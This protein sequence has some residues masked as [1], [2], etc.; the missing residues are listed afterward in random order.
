LLALLHQ[1]YLV[2]RQATALISIDFAGSHIVM[3]YTS[4]P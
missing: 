1:K 4:Y 3:V 2:K